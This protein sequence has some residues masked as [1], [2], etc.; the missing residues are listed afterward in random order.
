V[1]HGRARD[2]PR[3]YSIPSVA[4]GKAIKQVAIKQVA[5]KQVAIKQVAIKQVAI[6]QVAIKQEAIGH[7]VTQNMSQ[8]FTDEE[9][10]GAARKALWLMHLSF[11]RSAEIYLT[12]LC[13]TL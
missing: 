11:A 12:S 5:I 9:V 7:R 6:K 2:R 4:R 13:E 10:Y 8:S 3:D 1:L